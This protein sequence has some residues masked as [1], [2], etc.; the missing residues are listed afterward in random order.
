MLLIS[1]CKRKTFEILYFDLIGVIDQFTFTI[2][3]ITKVIW[4]GELR[5]IQ[6]RQNS[7]L[8]RW[9]SKLCDFKWLRL[10][11]PESRLPLR[12]SIFIIK[13]NEILPMVLIQSLYEQQNHSK[14]KNTFQETI[15]IF[16]TYNDNQIFRWIHID[17]CFY[18]IWRPTI[19]SKSISSPSSITWAAVRSSV[20]HAGCILMTIV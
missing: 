11:F 7:N 9:R 17:F 4:Y 3:S 6:T 15:Q 14:M 10:S 13:L 19:T 16:Q 12:L 2:E 20:I 1:R 8:Q 5:H 18:Q